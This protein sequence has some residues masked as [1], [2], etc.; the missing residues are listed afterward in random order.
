MTLRS[1]H[2]LWRIP[3]AAALCFLFPV[4]LFAVYPQLYW[5][6]VSPQRIFQADLNGLNKGTLVSTFLTTPAGVAADQDYVFYTDRGRD[7]IWR[8]RHDGSDQTLLVDLPGTFDDPYGI[9]VYGNFIYWAET[10]TDRIRKASITGGGV[11]DVVDSGLASPRG[12]AADMD[13]LFFTDPVLKSVLRVP[14]NG[15]SVT[16]ILDS[17]DGLNN[18]IGIDVQGDFIYWTDRTNNTINRADRDGNN[19]TVLVAGITDPQGVSV[20]RNH[21]YWTDLTEDIIERSDLSG[22]NIELLLTDLDGVGTPDFL[23]AIPEPRVAGLFLG[24]FAFF[25]LVVTSRRNGRSEL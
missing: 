11:T 22:G 3:I 8:I 23:V 12:I 14:R 5:A 15:G 7:E 9:A 20:H 2:L 19:P 6:N 10:G 25:F 21:I 17:T 18:P 4:S 13:Y 16:T 24:L 1:P